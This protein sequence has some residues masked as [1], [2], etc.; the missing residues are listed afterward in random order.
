[1]HKILSQRPLTPPYLA[2]LDGVATLTDDWAEAEGVVAGAATQFNEALFATTPKL[3]VV[4]R[5]GIGID[6]IDVAAAT[7][8]GVA[9][10]NAPDGPTISTAEHALALLL[11]VAKQIKVN[12]RRVR[13]E[14]RPFDFFS[15]NRGVELFGKTLGVVGLGRIG[16]HMSRLGQ[17]LGM[18][19]IGYDPFADVAEMAALGVTVLP[20]LEA[21][22]AQAD[23]VTLH[24]PRTPETVGL[25]NETRLRQMRPGAIL[26]NAA[27][28]GIV[29]EAALLTVLESGHL[30]GAGLDVFDV[31]PP[32]SDHPLL[33]RSDVVVSPH[34][35]SG[36]DLGKHKMMKTAVLQV[37]QVLQGIK[38]PH[39]V[40]PE[41]WQGA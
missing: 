37:V 33:L 35:A 16:R 13:E 15:H 19:V 25:M 38:P 32:T 8:Y 4:S 29:D 5:I 26:I 10:C 28:G 39:L 34:V 14:K 36:T 22:L 21:A 17:G 24:L 20:T 6:N 3:Q 7:R 31:E 11:A 18:T 30:L 1:M 27:R 12:E 41:V 9:V 23:V 2:L 40:N